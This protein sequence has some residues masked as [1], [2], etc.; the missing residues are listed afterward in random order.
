MIV[1]FVSRLH[2][3]LLETLM[4]W[5]TPPTHHHNNTISIETNPSSAVSSQGSRNATWNHAEDFKISSQRDVVVRIFCSSTRSSASLC[6]S[7]SC[8]GSW[9]F[10]VCVCV[11]T[12]CLH[13]EYLPPMPSKTPWM[14]FLEPLPEGSLQQMGG[15]DCGS[16][17]SGILALL[18][19]PGIPYGWWVCTIGY[20]SAAT[21]AGVLTV[22]TEGN[23]FQIIVFLWEWGNVSSGAK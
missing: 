5:H 16:L 3:S 1:S 11:L 20:V 19:W 17:C 12:V 23:G 14:T 13:A 2:H 22:S 10:Q 7:L 9:G 8:A 18:L 4:P 6:L 21:A 15:V